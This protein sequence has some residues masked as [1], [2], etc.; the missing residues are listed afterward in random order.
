MAKAC[1][2]KQLSEEQ[3]NKTFYLMNIQFF[4]MCYK[5]HLYIKCPIL[6]AIAQKYFVCITLPKIIR[7]T[8]LVH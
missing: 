5:M 4:Q 1:H 8:T 7:V 6:G 2:V 3:V